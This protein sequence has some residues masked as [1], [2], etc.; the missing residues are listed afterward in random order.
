MLLRLLS[1]DAVERALNQLITLDP[2]SATFLA[3]LAG[4]TIEININPPQWRIT[5]CITN[6]GVQI[7]EGHVDSPD[8]TIS[9]SP[10]AFAQ[11]LANESPMRTLFSGDLTIEGDMETGRKFQTL[12]KQLEIDWEEQLSRITGD[13]AAHK[14]GNL[15]RTG[16]KWGLESLN[17]FSLNLSEFIQEE[18]RMAPT[19]IEADHF[20]DNVDTLRED[21]DRLQARIKRL[22]ENLSP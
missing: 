2:D 22:Q 16:K 13:I 8:T 20:F 10:T 7:L 11:M 12:F 9:G 3:P 14:V 6:N 17:S 18:S 4:K 1:S 19:A 21:Y 15:F 5:L